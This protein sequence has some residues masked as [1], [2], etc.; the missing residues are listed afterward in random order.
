M[1]T[2]RKADFYYGALLSG[3]VNNG[4]APAIIEP[5]DSRRIYKI[6][7]DQGEYRIYAKYSSSPLKR[8]KQ[9]T[10]LW[11]FHFSKEEIMEVKG[12]EESNVI[13]KFAFICGKPESLQDSQIAI[14][15][16]MD[17]KDCLDVGFIRESHRITIKSQ[18]G[19]H[20]LKVYGTGRADILDGHD[21]T[22]RVPRG[23]AI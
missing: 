2:V 10:Q 15:N 19:A 5:G 18:K 11:Q 13:Y 16:L 9:T 1:S 17:L 8:K 3:F 21:N 6:A 23:L 22:I 7:N 20:G 14:L 12:I 4:V